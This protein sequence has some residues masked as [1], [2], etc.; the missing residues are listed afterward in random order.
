M[1]EQDEIYAVAASLVPQ[2]PA[3][4]PT[5]ARLV[6]LLQRA[7]GSLQDYCSELNGDMNDSL[8]EE[9]EETIA[10]LLSKTV[11]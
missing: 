1:S 3:A 11:E 2:P 6:E 10:P 7:A 8:A 4:V 5:T 9:I